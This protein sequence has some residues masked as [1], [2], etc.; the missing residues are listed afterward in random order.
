MSTL[1][2]DNIVGRDQQS[3]PNFP[4]GAVVTGVTTAATFAG[5]LQGN[6]STST[7]FA[8]SKTNRWS[9]F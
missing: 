3:S 5:D 4:K 7:K 1:R 6:A 8:S 2:A 9:C